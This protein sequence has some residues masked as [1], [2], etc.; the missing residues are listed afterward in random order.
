MKVNYLNFV[1]Q[2]NEEKKY[3][4]PILK[5]V[6]GSGHY[7]GVNAKEITKFE[8]NVKKLIGTKYAI[9]LNSGTDALTLAMHSMGIKRGDEVITPSNSYVASTGAIVHL[10]AVPVFVDVLPDQNIDPKKIEAAITKKTKAIMPVHLTGRSCQM[11]EIMKISKK[12]KIPVVEDCAQAFGSKFKNKSCGSFGA[13][14]CFSTHPL[15]NLNG[16]GDG[17]FV[18]TNDQKIAKYIGKIRNH[19]LKSRDELECFGYVSRMD[20]IQAAILNFRLSKIKKI[21]NKRRYNAKYYHN[22]LDRRYIYSPPENRNQF[23][24]Y[25]TFVIQVPNRDKLKK[26]LKT[27]KISTYVHYPI[28]IHKQNAYKKM[29]FKTAPL[30]VTELQSRQ[31]LSIPVHHNLTKKKLKYV[32]DTIN[33]FYK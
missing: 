13:V 10:G 29:H 3:L 7:V 4:I 28:P 11:D 26:F 30:P 5:K 25:H 32:V 24:T 9:A 18:V 14:G 15:K 12:Y 1:D 22:K 21:I 27:K 17:G 20:N 19:G 8:N 2:W 23:N 16:M 33:S 6:M 31:I